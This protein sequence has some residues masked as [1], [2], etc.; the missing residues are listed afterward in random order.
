MNDGVLAWF[1]SKGITP[2]TVSDFGITVNEEH[3][4]VFPYGTHS[5]TRYG[6]PSGD[7]RFIWPKGV[8]VQLF[9]A[10][11]SN[12]PYMFLC[13]GETD[14]MRLR[15][16]LGDSKDV[17]VLGIPGIE[18]WRDSMATHFDGAEKIW[19]LFDNDVDYMVQS[20]VDAA[21]REIRAELGPRAKRVRLPRGVKD[22]CEFF[23]DYDLEALKMLLE[24]TPGPGESRF[25][26]LD[27]TMEPP[28]V[29]WLVDRWFCMGDIHLLI[30]EPGI[31]KSWL[32]MALAVAVAHND[33]SDSH[34]LG[35][36]VYQRGRVLYLD[37][38]NP[39]DLVYD[40]FRKLGL[41]KDDAKQI[42]YLNNIGIRLDRNPDELIDE[43]LDYEPT[44]IVL[45]S[46][47]R[48]HTEDEN[49]AGA[50]AGLFHNAIKPLARETG[51]AVVLIHHANK[52]ESNSSYKRSRGSGD[53]TASVDAGFDVRQLG[54]GILS[55][56]N[57]KSRRAAQGDT[58]YMSI[59]D[60]PDG[61]V[62]LAG[63][64]N[65]HV[66]F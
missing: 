1:L 44:L 11:E 19:V 21:W 43:A 39:E 36:T 7:R 12:R 34:F 17:G 4:V 24:R 14:T 2:K 29:R 45:D 66:P 30:G 13:E 8:D 40:R 31:G 20:R 32:T 10:R 33:E 22:I 55:I 3:G 59:L 64:D 46:L 57:F 6:I 16:E 35:H 18:T 56:T 62:V 37:E 27:L 63:G 9:N 38:E 41:T 61:S 42:R 60:K 25:K 49:H 26:T 28:P 48:F 54:E 23:Q 51:A 15:Q 65:V 5:K 50:M 47:T 58:F 53:I 52:T